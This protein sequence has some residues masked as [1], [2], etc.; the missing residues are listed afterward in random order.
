MSCTATH[1]ALRRGEWRWAP[2]GKPLRQISRMPGRSCPVIVI[3]GRRSQPRNVPPPDLWVW[4]GLVPPG[5]EESRIQ[6]SQNHQKGDL[7]LVLPIMNLLNSR[8]YR[9]VRSRRKARWA[10]QCKVLRRK[11]GIKQL[12]PTAPQGGYGNQRV[13]SCPVGWSLKSSPRLRSEIPEPQ[14]PP[15]KN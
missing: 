6:T 12:S 7:E 2:N 11:R 5:V 8:K 9:L 10:V 14:I 3:L 1:A 13:K 15:C 4:I